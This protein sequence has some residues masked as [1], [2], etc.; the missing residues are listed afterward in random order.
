MRMMKYDYIIE[1]VLGKSLTAA[2]TLSQTP[3]PEAKTAVN[4]V[5]WHVESALPTSR[6]SLKLIIAE[7]HDDDVCQRLIQFGQRGWPPG[8]TSVFR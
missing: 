7:Q 8:G 5:V 1:H 3:L 2:D 6:T 4:S